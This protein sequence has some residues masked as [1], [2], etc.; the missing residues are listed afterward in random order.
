MLK[1]RIAPAVVPLALVLGLGI[2]CSG[3]FVF[4]GYTK[5][6][7]ID[8]AALDKLQIGQ[9]NAEVVENS[10]GLPDE[11]IPVGSGQIYRYTYSRT[12][13]FWLLMFAHSSQQDDKLYIYFTDKGLLAEKKFQDKTK[14]LGWRVW[15]FGR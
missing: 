14:D 6:E 1:Q 9:A 3:C 12:N 11:I 2:V 5:G 7:P 4:H 15:P 13:T 8:T 10:L